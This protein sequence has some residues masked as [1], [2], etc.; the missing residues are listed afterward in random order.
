MRSRLTG[1]ESGLDGK[2][3]NLISRICEYLLMED[4]FD[5]RDVFGLDIELDMRDFAEYD[6][7]MSMYMVRLLDVMAFPI[8][9]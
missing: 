6:A 7:E 2:N 8:P 1:S 4:D 3:E 5:Y 9:F